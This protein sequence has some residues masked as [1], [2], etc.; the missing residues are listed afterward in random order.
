[1]TPIA[2][3][4]SDADPMVMPMKRP[5]ATVVSIVTDAVEPKYMFVPDESTPVANPAQ[6]LPTQVADAPSAR[7]T[8]KSYSSRNARFVPEVARARASDAPIDVPEVDVPKRGVIVMLPGDAP[9][10]VMIPNAVR[11]HS[12][13][14]RSWFAAKPAKFAT[15]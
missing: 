9:A 8:T 2:V 14:E 11:C 7:R 15:E 1:M 3:I 5:E 10:V 6:P 13:P 4:E 12:W